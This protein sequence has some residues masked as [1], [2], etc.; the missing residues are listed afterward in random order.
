MKKFLKANWVELLAGVAI[1][2]G[3][4]L[5]VDPGLRQPIVKVFSQLANS[6]FKT[7]KATVAN[8]SHFLINITPATFLGVILVGGA[9]VLILWRIRY[10]LERS[11]RFTS[12]N[13]PRCN[14]KLVRLH[15]RWI[16][17]IFTKLFLPHTHRYR[18]VNRECGW[19][20]L[21]HKRSHRHLEGEVPSHHD[22]PHL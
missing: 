8:L 13:C 3:G 21:L 22:L 19:S 7:V 4:F 20:G 11:P 10:R 17:R 1:L 5:L 9:L 15:R 14:G 2:F 6:L 16:D 18:C 12:E